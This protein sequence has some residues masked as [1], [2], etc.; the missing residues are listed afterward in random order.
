MVVGTGSAETNRTFFPNS[1]VLLSWK[2]LVQR[3]RAEFALQY[4][5]CTGQRM[6]VKGTGVHLI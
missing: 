4:D 3:P 1:A 5:V 6:T 2:S